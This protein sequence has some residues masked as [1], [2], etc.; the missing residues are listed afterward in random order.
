MRILFCNYEYPPLGGGGGVINALLAEELATRHEVTVLTSRGMGLPAESVVNGVR[1]VRAP[2]FF[3]QKRV[4]LNGQVFEVLKFRSM[5]VDAEGDGRA[6]LVAV[7]VAGWWHGIVVAGHGDAEV[8]GPR[9]PRPRC[10]RWRHWSATAAA[11]SR[12]STCRRS[13]PRAS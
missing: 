5:T 6:E 1:I 2:V 4:G 8:A 11:R 10:H 9:P 7:E 3:R 12:W 13:S